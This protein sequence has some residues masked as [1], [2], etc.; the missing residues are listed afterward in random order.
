MT[1]NR[2]RALVTGATGFVGS[3]LVRRLVAEDFEVSVLIRPGSDLEQLTPVMA[4]VRT[5]E[6][7]GCT[8][9]LI[10]SVGEADPDVVF[11]LASH[12][13]AEHRPQQVT[14]LVDS[15]VRLGAQLLEAMAMNGCRRLVNAGTSWQHFGDSGYRPVCLYAATK[16]AFE[17]ILDFY[18]DAHEFHS[19]TLKLLDTYGPDDR[20]PK[21]FSLLQKSARTG[22]AL[23][24]SAGEQLIDL[25]YIDDAIEAF[26]IAG[27]RLLR[28][29]SGPREEYAV[30]SGKPVSLRQLVAAYAR[31]SG[32]DLPVNWGARPYRRREVMIP[33]S[34]GVPLPGWAP[35]V[36]LEVGIERM[37]NQDMACEVR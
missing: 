30:S 23:D 19:I 26:L 29:E 28:G 15:N 25:V 12:F 24:L 31:V 3:R 33:W 18:I 11:H 14:E 7:D 5:V 27:N 8:G 1:E 10:D 35:R 20:R 4:S 34:T 6:H 13:I 22:A 36:P 32:V 2:K 9:N 17:A 37:V 21:L 16:Q